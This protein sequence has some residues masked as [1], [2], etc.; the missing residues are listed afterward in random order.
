M[1]KTSRVLP[2]AFL[3]AAALAI[4]ACGSDSNS[5]G[6][7]PKASDTSA[8]KAIDINPQPRDSVKDGGTMTWAIDQFSTQWNYNQLDGPEYSTFWVENA[9]MPQ[10]FDADEK[11]DVTANPDFITKAEVTSTDPEVITLTLNKDAKW[12]DG[13]P[14]TE[15]DYE[16]QWKALS[17]KD[18]AFQTA[19]TT[20][21]D[22][23]KSV[24]QGDD[25]YTVVVTLRQ[26]VRRVEVAVLAPVPGRL[27]VDPGEVQQGLLQRHPG[28]GRP[29][30]AAED[31]QDGQDGHGRARSEV[32]GRPGQARQD[33]LPRPRHLRRDQ[34]VH[35]R[36]G[37]PRRRRSRPERVQAHEGDTRLDDP[38]GRW[39]RLPPLHD[40]RHGAEPHRRQGA[41]GRRGRHQPRGDREVRPDRAQLA[42]RD[43]G[44]PLL[45]QH[46]GRLPGQHG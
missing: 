12:S 31:R 46:A 30:Q 13:K 4:G 25:E 29:V 26:A 15:R 24:T 36:R 20:G 23:I 39:S 8:G 18:E 10:P 3:A 32:V 40:Q 44:Q 16:T 6:S 2:A 28:H 38:R 41:P 7:T 43:D 33:R 9:V 37:R 45:R 42:G 11:A 35:Q 19:S 1:I 14:I 22:R 5:G 21:Y 34:R 17:G 27:P